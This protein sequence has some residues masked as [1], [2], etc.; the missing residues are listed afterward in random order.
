MNRMWIAA[1]VPLVLMASMCLAT[2][3]NPSPGEMNSIAWLALLASAL[4]TGLCMLVVVFM[5]WRSG[6][7]RLTHPSIL[8]TLVLASLD[9]LI[10]TTVVLLFRLFIQS[11]KN[12][13]G[14]SHVLR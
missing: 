9:V 14:L 5:G 11:V 13:W 3:L 2:S 7:Y 8:A 6:H 10:P 12:S 1:A 4:A